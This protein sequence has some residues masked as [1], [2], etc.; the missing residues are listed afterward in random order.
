MTG[1]AVQ[2]SAG[3]SMERTVFSELEI[4]PRAVCL[5]GDLY[6]VELVVRLAQ[7]VQSRFHFSTSKRSESFT[8]KITDEPLPQLYELTE[9]ENLMISTDQIGGIC[10]YT[11]MT[12]DSFLLV[13]A[14]LGLVQCRALQTSCY[15]VSEDFVHCVPTRCLYARSESRQEYAIRLEHGLICGGC[16]EF[17]SRLGLEPELDTLLHVLEGMQI[18]DA[19]GEG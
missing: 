4:T 6:D 2:V 10:L 19:R 1:E 15:L 16:R 13:S 9:H 17:Y 14:L 18:H 3:K 8:V 7:K 12:Q 11:G 5:E